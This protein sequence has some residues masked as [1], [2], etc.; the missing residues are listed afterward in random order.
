MIILK[1]D[2]IE[3]GYRNQ[4]LFLSI[5]IF[6]LPSVLRLCLKQ[7]HIDLTNWQW[8]N[9]WSLDSAAWEQKTQLRSTKENP[10]LCKFSFVLSLSRIVYQ[11]I[12]LT[13]RGTNK[14]HMKKKGTSVS[15]N[16]IWEN[17][18][19]FSKWRPGLHC[20]NQDYIVIR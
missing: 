10:F 8:R 4:W 20:D 9:R 18:Q 14:P 12:I 2:H 3:F 7:A 5:G 11:I 17:S 16:R 19:L 1:Q 13:L 15:C 6:L